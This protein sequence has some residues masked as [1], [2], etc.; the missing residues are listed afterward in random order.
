MEKSSNRMNFKD[1]QESKTGTFKRLEKA[2][3]LSASD[4]PK[5]QDRAREYRVA[6]DV[7]SLKDQRRKRKVG[8]GRSMRTEGKKSCPEGEYYCFDESKCKPIPKGHKVR[9]D[10]EL[11]KEDAKYGYDK[12]GNSL[13][14]KDKKKLPKREEDEDPRSM[15]TKYRNIKN[16]MR[17]MGLKMSYEPEI[18]DA[19]E[20]FYEQ[21]ITAEGIDL[22]I[23]EVGLDT[24]V[25]FVIKSEFLSEERP[26]RK[27]NV[28]TKKTVQK[29]VEKIKA[30]KSDVVPRGTPKDT[31][32]RARAER[33]L[34]KPKLAKPSAPAKK[35]E[36]S[37]TKVKPTQPE[38][39]STTKDGIK[40]GL[41][42]KITSAVKKGVE[43]H[44]A[45][46]KNNKFVK[47][48]ESGVKA[49][50]KAVKDVHSVT[51]VNKSRTVNMQS[52]ELEGDVISEDDVVKVEG[53]FGYVEFIDL[54]KPEPMKGVSGEAPPG[55]EKQVKALKKKFPNDPAAP[56]KIAWAQHNKESFEIDKSAH[57]AAQKKA[58]IRN[59]AKDNTN[60]H[61]KA[62]AERK[63]GGPKL[64]GEGKSFGEYR[65]A[66][67]SVFK[68]KET[69]PHK[70]PEGT[71]Y[72]DPAD[73]AKKKLKVAGQKAAGI[74]P[75]AA[76]EYPE[77]S[78]SK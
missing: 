63:A 67:S 32:G 30:N 38:K 24:F 15:G 76:D 34:K 18:N 69:P 46:T 71:K 78:S 9:E 65:K 70:Y 45:A 54:V 77:R 61:E 74:I 73:A 27:M 31:L 10:G 26:A 20:Y 23:E 50:G 25:D 43:R 14:P 72:K 44:Q 49:V 39:T 29:E 5:K 66:V 59:L 52:Y 3:V 21:G 2:S 64:Y 22:I 55:R 17:A 48:V 40:S 47:G 42:S 53:K 41:R 4:D 56:Y 58:K 16:Q 37:V 51:Q 35:V 62:A 1:F 75:D 57:K 12:D 13:N 11:V 19:V 33:S 6:A 60:P 36:K 28:R 68:K 7:K 8:V